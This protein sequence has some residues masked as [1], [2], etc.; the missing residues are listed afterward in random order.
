LPSDASADESDVARWVDKLLVP[1][2][3]HLLVHA[4]RRA[5]ERATAPLLARI[6]QLEAELATLRRKMAA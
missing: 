5:A 3:A 2:I 4:R 6:A 1:H